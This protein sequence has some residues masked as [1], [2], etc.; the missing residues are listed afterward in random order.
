MDYAQQQRSPTKHLTGMA[1]VI[2]L[3]AI[4]IYAM[5]TGLA[6]KV[7]DVIKQ[8][9]ETK[10]IEEVK[11]PPPPDTPPPPPPKLAVPPP[12]FIP[13]PE[14]QVTQPQQLAPTIT[15]TTSAPPPVAVAPM[16]APPVEKKAVSVRTD[17]V[18]DSAMCEKPEYPR[19]SRKNQETGTV[20]VRFLIGVDG[21][22]L[23]SQIESSSGHRR[24]DEAARRGLGLCRFKPGTI[25]GKAQQ[26]WA[27]IQYV[28]KLED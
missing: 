3:H 22:V 1:I 11:P 14:I 27:R 8:P 4:I 6:R 21:K 7:V 9:L 17:P 25:D 16:Q 23:D 26:S 5:V 12:P 10:I 13:P 18:I 20:T 24:L 15:A 2:V 19:E 28:W